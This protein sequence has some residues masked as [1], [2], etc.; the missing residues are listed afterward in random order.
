MTLDEHNDRRDRI[1]AHEKATHGV[2][3]VPTG[4]MM[5]DKLE[6]VFKGVAGYASIM[7]HKAERLA[8]EVANKTE[9]IEQLEAVISELRKRLEVVK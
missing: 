8:V 9:Q 5:R 2:A 7:E 4:R 6:L 1:I 3:D